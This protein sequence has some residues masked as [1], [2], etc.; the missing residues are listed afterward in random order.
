MSEKGISDTFESFA[1]DS[2]THAGADRCVCAGYLAHAEEWKMFEVQWRKILD[3]VDVDAFHSEEFYRRGPKYRA[4]SE[5]HRE[6]F[7]SD[8]FRVISGRDLSLFGTAIDVPLFLSLSE[9]ER[10]YLTDGVYN[11]RKKKWVR[12]G[13]PNR[14]FYMPFNSCINILGH[15]VP[16]GKVL[17][18]TI[19]CQGDYEPWM[20]EIYRR[21]RSTEGLP[22]RQKLAEDISFRS[23]KSVMALQAADLAAY[24]FYQYSLLRD[25]R[26]PGS[27]HFQRLVERLQDKRHLRLFN[28]H[29][30]ELVLE[31]MSNSNVLRPLRT[32]F[33][34]GSTNLG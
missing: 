29:G 17:S 4:W 30:L 1:D 26:A 10:R 14:P 7:I 12:S 13:S 22:F 3:R 11:S 28:R 20:R 32:S 25:S 16:E 15:A 19:S 33:L 18:M 5:K 31:G 9:H 2:G 23:Y 21:V 8:L 34:E 24:H 27:P 6:N